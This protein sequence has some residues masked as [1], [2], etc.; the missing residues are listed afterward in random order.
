MRTPLCLLLSLI[1]SLSGCSLP[2]D[3]ES[4]SE[5]VQGGTLRIGL[6]SQRMDATDQAALDAVAEA[7]SA[8]PD[9]VDGSVHQLISMLEKGEIDIA[10]GGIPADTPFGE[11]VGLSRSYGTVAIGDEERMRVLA[12]RK[13]ENGF[14]TRI[15]KVLPEHE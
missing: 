6:L 12:V 11:Q 5:R 9:I 3:P 7:F 2:K 4:T 14:L 13:G 1:L 8:S 15:E 10:I